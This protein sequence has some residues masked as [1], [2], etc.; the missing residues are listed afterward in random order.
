MEDKSQAAEPCVCSYVV[1]MSPKRGK[2]CEFNSCFIF[3][4][5]KSQTFMKLWGFD[6]S[7]MTVFLILSSPGKI[8]RCSPVKYHYSSSIL[9]RN[10]PTD[11]TK[12]I[13]QDEWH[14][15]R[16]SHSTHHSLSEFR[17]WVKWMLALSTPRKG[18]LI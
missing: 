2:G 5:A 16:K 10:L 18:L 11:I 1:L 3:S 15:L 17:D 9:P 6:A 8:Q 4:C 14:A 12:T 7:V 13:R